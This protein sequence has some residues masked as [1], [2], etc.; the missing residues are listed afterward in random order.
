MPMLANASLRPFW[1]GNVRLIPGMSAMVDDKW[2]DHKRMATL[3]DSGAI[4]DQPAEKVEAKPAPTPPRPAVAPT[5]PV[6][7]TPPA[8]T[9]EA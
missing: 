3:M 6:G 7:R 9:K 4:K 8:A 2:M 5:Q 1:F